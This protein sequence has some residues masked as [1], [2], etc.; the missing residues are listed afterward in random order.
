MIEEA[1]KLIWLAE[2]YC[3]SNNCI[4]GNYLALT[5]IEMLEDALERLKGLL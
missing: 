4:P 1:E 5:A 2:K 3:F